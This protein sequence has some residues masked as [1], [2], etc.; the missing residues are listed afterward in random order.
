[1][2]RQESQVAR[3]RAASAAIDAELHRLSAPPAASLFSA[4][5]ARRREL[6]GQSQE[7]IRHTCES[8]ERSSK[9]IA[10]SLDVI[11]RG[12]SRSRPHGR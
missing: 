11:A 5:V 12:E 1:M 6:I 7:S 10:R 8:I 9:L 3:V 2:A 4:T